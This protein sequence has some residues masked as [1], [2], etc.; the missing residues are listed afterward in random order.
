MS[1]KILIVDDETDLETL[2]S[3]KFRKQIN[4][5][6]LCFVFAHNGVEAIEK[7]KQD[8]EIEVIFTDINMPE[9]DGLTLLNKLNLYR[10]LFKAVVVSAYGDM[11]NIRT[12]MNLGASDFIIKPIDFKDLEITITKTLEQMQA[13]KDAV[14]TKERM[15]DI[16]KELVVAKTIQQSFLPS[17]LNMDSEQAGFEIRATMIPA[18]EVG[19]D[20]FDFFRLSPQHLGVVIADV[21]GKGISAALFMAVTKTLI[22][23]L[24]S[25]EKSPKQTL[26][27]VNQILS[28]INEACMFVT[29]FYGILDLN[30]GEFRFCNAGHNPPY[31]FTE[32]GT[33]KP[34][35]TEVG[36]ALGVVD[37]LF[38]PENTVSLQKNDTLVLYTDGVSEAMNAQDELYGNPRLE[39]FLRTAKGLSINQLFE[40][41]LSDVSAFVKG[42][43]QS[44]DITLLL[45]KYVKDAHKTA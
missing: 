31:I 41:I 39:S 18:K 42:H 45:V 30:T 44:D 1:S 5:K 4:E 14:L 8:P 22:R 36:I 23:A 19:G 24:S 26:S 29:T 35:E 25:P 6:K 27:H 21:S 12:A 11:S 20:F 37:D 13:L 17:T 10:K 2:I 38:G 40:G 43:H 7:L 16:E 28:Q 9:M 34:I 3:H 33:I 32:D 15:N